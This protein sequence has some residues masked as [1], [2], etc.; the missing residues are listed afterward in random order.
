[1][2]GNLSANQRCPLFGEFATFWPILV[3]RSIYKIIFWIFLG[4]CVHEHLEES[5]N[6]GHFKIQQRSNKQRGQNHEYKLLGAGQNSHILSNITQFSNISKVSL[7]F[8]SLPLTE[9]NIQTEVAGKRINR[10]GGYGLE[11]HVQ[12]RFTG[13]AKA[14][15]QMIKKLEKVEK[16]MNKC[17]EK[18]LK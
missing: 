9:V 10:A 13:P 6:R 2:Q 12:Y 16:E 8:L 17:V 5:F 14:L 3:E 18:F 1:M 4:S 11:I 7:I 15:R